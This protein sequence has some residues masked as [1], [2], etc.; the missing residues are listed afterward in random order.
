KELERTASRARGVGLDVGVISAA[1]ARRLLPAI[2][3]DS[4]YGAG[5]LPRD[6]FLDPHTATFAL[7]DAAR[8]LGIRIRQNARVTGFDTGLGPR[9]EIRRVLLEGGEAIDT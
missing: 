1:E 2:A 3:P 4:P 6:G 7:A 5:H 8:R 9:R